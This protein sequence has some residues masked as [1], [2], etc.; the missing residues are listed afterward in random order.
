MNLFI[1]VVGF[2][3]M[4]LG[5][6]FLAGSLIIGS[7]GF[8]YNLPTVLLVVAGVTILN[9]GWG[10]RRFGWLLI[11]IGIVVAFASGGIAIVPVTLFAFGVAMLAIVNGYSMLSS[12]KVKLRLFP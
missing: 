10:D 11:I 8:I 12:G 9:Y 5:I 3:I 6:K 1:R 4:I 2:L 7:A